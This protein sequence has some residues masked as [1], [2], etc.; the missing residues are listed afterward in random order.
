MKDTKIEDKTDAMFD[1]SGPASSSGLAL[2]E[3]SQPVSG[4][5]P[6]SASGGTRVA[7]EAQADAAETTAELIDEAAA[8]NPSFAPSCL[9]ENT[10]DREFLVWEKKVL[11]DNFDCLLNVT[12]SEFLIII[13]VL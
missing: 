8:P 4:P 1:A 11:T 5:A 10:A 13:T 7:I 9:P 2:A 6:G 3:S 12:A